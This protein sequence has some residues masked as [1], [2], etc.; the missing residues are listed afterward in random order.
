MLRNLTMYLPRAFLLRHAGF[1]IA[2]SFKHDGSSLSCRAQVISRDDPWTD[3]LH[4]LEA[5]N[6][7]TGERTELCWGRKHCCDCGTI[8]AKLEAHKGKEF[9]WKACDLELGESHS[10]ETRAADEGLSHQAYI[11][12]LQ[13]RPSNFAFL[14]SPTDFKLL[15][16]SLGRSELFL[17]FLSEHL[18][19]SY[20]PGFWV[21][22]KFCPK[23]RQSR[24]RDTVHCLLSRSALCQMTQQK[25]S[26]T[27]GTEP[28]PR[29]SFLMRIEVFFFF[30][31]LLFFRND[32]SG[33]CQFR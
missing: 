26:T 25:Q 20:T 2:S 19:F 28:E 11:V 17:F 8:P 30:P 33:A 13:V 23:Q 9:L 18:S 5:L 7:W 4:F 29:L 15:L 12:F 27:C 14:S 31:P 24:S 3:V 10:G 22:W 32:G 16:F 21:W 6:S 1:N